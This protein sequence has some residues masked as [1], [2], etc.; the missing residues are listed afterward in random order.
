MI[1]LN[2]VRLLIII[3]MTVFSAILGAIILLFTFSRNW[4]IG[5]SSFVWSNVILFVCGVRL[6][7][8]NIERCK[9]KGMGI[10]VANH[11]S[12][13]DIPAM[14][15]A[16]PVPLYFIAKKELSKVPFMGWYMHLVG[17]IFIDRSDKEKAYQSIAKAGELIKKGRTV[18]TFPEG[19][20]SMDGQIGTFKR[21]SFILA[22][23]AKIPIFPV[24]IKGSYEVL[25]PGKFRIVPGTIVVNF[26]EAILPESY[27]GMSVEELAVFCKG[28]VQELIAASA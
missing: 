28:K 1:V 21:G 9:G 2:L 18:M 20:R 4:A 25:P 27:A 3:V 5:G 7:V 13:M 6:K 14:F 12:H 26:G 23:E 15:L 8:N 17:M 22:K 24:G 16:S 10:F 19:T 11:S